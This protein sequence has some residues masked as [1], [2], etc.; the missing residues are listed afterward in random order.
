MVPWYKSSAKLC[1]HY[2]AFGFKNKTHPDFWNILWKE[3]Q[4]VLTLN[5]INTL[6]CFANKQSWGILL[7]DMWS[8]DDGIML[9]A[10]S[11]EEEKTDYDSV[12]PCSAIFWKGHRSFLWLKHSGIAQISLQWNDKI[13]LNMTCNK[14]SITTRKKR[15]LCNLFLLFLHHSWG[16]I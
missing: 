9:N 12:D 8:I 10:Q 5:I 4:E 7:N 13:C 11:K 16:H 6:R 2:P 3:R 14:V 1:G 15:I